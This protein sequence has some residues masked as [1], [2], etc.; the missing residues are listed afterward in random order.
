MPIRINRVY[1]KTGDTGETCLAS[2]ERVKKYHPRVECYGMLDELNV[3]VGQ[4][5]TQL[6]NPSFA[7]DSLQVE[8]WIE[9]LQKIQNSLFDLGSYLS[10]VY[11]N[12]DNSPALPTSPTASDIQQLEEWMDQ[13]G[14]VLEPLKSFTLPG[15]LPENI[16]AHQCR[17]VAR[18]AERLIVQL[19][20]TESI[21]TVAIQYINRLSDLFFVWS[22]LFSHYSKKKEYVWITGLSK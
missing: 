15:G 9:A 20:E 1:T 7:V 6:E 2:G 11:P 19:A 12:I 4:L 17:V 14:S 22:R 8:I 5:R 3:F 21:H 13:W 10:L 18:K 16:S